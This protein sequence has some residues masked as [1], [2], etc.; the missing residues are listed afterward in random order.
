MNK[1][2]ELRYLYNEHVL[3]NTKKELDRLRRDSWQQK[4]KEESLI[5]TITRNMVSWLIA[6][7]VKWFGY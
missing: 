3:A 1:E 6:F 4:H 5:R 2:D 7:K